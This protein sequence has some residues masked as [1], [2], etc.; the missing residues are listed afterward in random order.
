MKREFNQDYLTSKALVEGESWIVQD[1]LE[2]QR[3]EVVSKICEQLVKPPK[4]ADTRVR[5]GYPIQDSGKEDGDSGG[6]VLA[7][8]APLYLLPPESWQYSR[9]RELK[10]STHGTARVSGKR[11][12]RIKVH[13]EKDEYLAE[14]RAFLND[15]LD[16]LSSTRLKKISR[17]ANPFVLDDRGW[18]YRLPHSIRGKPRDT[19]D[20]LR[21]VVPSSLREDMLHHA[22]EAFQGGRQGIT[23]THGKLRTE[24][25]WPGIYADVQRFV[26]KCMDC[27]SG[28]G[29]PPNAG[30][31]PG[32]IEPR[33][34]IEAVS[35]DFVTHMP[36]SAR[37]NTFVL[38]FQDMFSGYVMYVVG[39]YEE[40]V[41]Q[42]FGVSFMIRHDQ[43]PRF[44][45]EV[46]TRFR[47]RLGSRQRA[48]LG[49]RPQ[50]NRQQERSVQTVIR[51]VRS[52]VAEIDQSD[53]D[54]DAERLMFALNVSF[55][56]ARLD[57]PFYLVHG[58]DA[59][60][61]VSAMLG[62][63]PSS[64]PERSAYEW[65]WKLQ[66]GYNYALACAEDLQKKAKKMCSDKQTRKWL[67][68]S[69]RVKVGFEKGNFVW[70]YISKVHTGLSQKLAHMWHGPFRIDE[71]RDDFRVKLKMKDTGYRVNPWVHISRLKPRVVF[72]KISTVEV[73]VADDDVS[74]RRCCLKTVG[75]LTAQMMCWKWSQFRTYDGRNTPE[76][77]DDPDNTSSNG[78]GMM[79]QSG[80][81]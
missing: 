58:W 31:S 80:F 29:V 12:R 69:E 33:Y 1:D 53:W 59:R 41:F 52:Y 77:R 44:M 14:I 15:D 54:D 68:L 6:T 2:K 39:A 5:S 35:M 17:V 7:L 11:W 3:L 13:Q 27:A 62:P 48:T 81:R 32:N 43:D 9:D 21:L 40:Q 56:E 10:N 49:Y 79:T 64:I 4:D 73:D 19:V 8:R 34:P 20:N 28:K 30:P 36:E 37:G 61:T 50:A 60:R 51:S 24:F 22:H 46:F 57:T 72:P 25:Y 18:L 55:D 76:L 26:K 42:R 78:S 47:E 38:L 74:M 16:R 75:S 67:G 66:R 65:R 63:K 71:I 70:Q 45:S 23:R